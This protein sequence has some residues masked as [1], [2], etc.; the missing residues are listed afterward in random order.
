MGKPQPEIE[1]TKPTKYRFF[2]TW[3]GLARHMGI[4]PNLTA[5]PLLC[6]TLPWPGCLTLV[7][8]PRRKRG[9]RKGSKERRRRK[10]RGGRLTA[11]LLSRNIVEM[12]MTP[13][14]SHLSEDA[15]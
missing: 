8:A 12:R 11:M 2:K 15:S 5:C 6:R 4:L 14:L 1:N 3:S 13:T 7:A 10:R 9:E